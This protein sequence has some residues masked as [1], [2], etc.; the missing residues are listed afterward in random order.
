MHEVRGCG[1]LC[2]DERR[3]IMR[4]IYR[5]LAVGLVTGAACFF[6]SVA[7]PGNV[8]DTVSVKAAAVSTQNQTATVSALTRKELKKEIKKAKQAYKSFIKSGEA[9]EEY[10]GHT[11]KSVDNFHFTVKD[12]NQDQIP[13]LI[14]SDVTGKNFVLFTYLNGKVSNYDSNDNVDSNVELSFNENQNVL[15]YK[16]QDEEGS[17][18]DYSIQKC[19]PDRMTKKLLLV[20]IKNKNGGGST[21]KI[22]SA[23]VTKD[24]F[25]QYLRRYYKKSTVIKT[26]ANNKKNRAKLL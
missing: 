18:I 23:P 15:I 5:K 2:A 26:V 20:K 13:E 17:V 11:L 3:L 22:N 10:Q 14:L 1:I 24:V 19:D 16:F 9:L 6:I 12:V 21:F 4:Q 7:L 8:G 25:D